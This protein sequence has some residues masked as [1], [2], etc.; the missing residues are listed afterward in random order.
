MMDE[1]QEQKSPVGNGKE[2]P[3]RYDGKL[4]VLGKAKYAAEFAKEIEEQFKGKGML[5]AYLVVSNIASGEIISMDTSAADHASGVVKILTPFNAPKLPMVAPQP[6]ATRKLSLL[7]DRTV[8]Y[9]GEPIGIVLAKSQVEAAHA[10]SLIKVKYKVVP[11]KLNFDK[12]LG[13][14]R[15]PKGGNAPKAQKHGDEAAAWAKATTVVEH[16]YSTPLQT[17]NPMEPHATIAAWEADKLTVY[18]ATQYISGDKQ[19]LAKHFSLP[20][21]SVHVI[22]PYVGGGFGSKGSTWSHVVLCAL[23]AKVAGVPVKLVMERNQMFGP[24]GGRPKTVQTIKLG[25]DN[26]GKLVAI[27][28]DVIL[29]ASVMEDF[30]E[31]AANQTTMLYQCDQISTSHKMVDM[32]IGVQTFQRAP[33]EAVGTA[34]LESAMDELA[35]KLNMDPLQLRM[36]NYAEKDPGQQ[37]EFS[38]KHLK[39]A[40]TQAA[41]RFGWTKRNS[42]PGAMREGNK[43]IGYGMATATY[44]ANRSA[45]MAVIRLQANGRMFIG[46][47]TQDLGTGMYTMMAQTVM[48][49]LDVPWEMIDVKLGDSTLPKAPVSGG[50]Q[51]TASVGPAVKEAC[52]QLKLKLANMAAA[53]PSSKLYGAMVNDI[54]VKGG[55]L[56]SKTDASKSEPL[57]ASIARNKG[58]AIEETGSGEPSQEAQRALS[59]HSWGAV[60]AE[61]AVDDHTHMV[62]V[63]RVVATYDIGKLLNKKTGMSQLEGGIVWGIGTALTEETVLDNTTGRIVN[64]NLAEYHVPVNLDA[65]II[66][67]TV[68]DTP[69]TK[70]NPQGAR[71]VGEIGI[72]G[73]AGAIAN[74]IFNATGK[75][76]RDFPIT[77]DKIMAA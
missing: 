21:D 53:D 22:D 60:F 52:N 39:D 27:Q 72:T 33:G 55:M 28:H 13:E 17:H 62:E 16:T 1:M 64:N 71:G 12:R 65:G 4:K 46:S 2:L 66:D 38:S 19:T 40:Y 32:N 51:S 77:P 8:Y 42:T 47:G 10:A 7:Q 35:I 54:E 15:M 31:A 73:V 44:P 34:A 70:F 69:D 50:S 68:I 75:R 29:P 20:L 37:K 59:T 76:V 26:T 6:P 30:M 5:Y 43:H 61:V 3:V 18:D 14:A 23:A 25:T 58:A 49:E 74:A 56:V 48:Q 67:V 11:S 57:A 45:A 41:E 9:N 24:V 63:R 36:L